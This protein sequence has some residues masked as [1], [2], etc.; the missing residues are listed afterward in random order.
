MSEV[1]LP[2]CLAGRTGHSGVK[3]LQLESHTLDSPVLSPSTPQI[4]TLEEMCEA[5]FKALKANSSSIL[6]HLQTLDTVITNN[7]LLIKPLPACTANLL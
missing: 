6:K 1:A 7:S 3:E 4:N 2:L 5:V